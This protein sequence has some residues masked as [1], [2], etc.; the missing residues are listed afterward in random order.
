[1]L[2]QGVSKAHPE[3][4]SGSWERVQRSVQE[5]L[6]CGRDPLLVPPALELGLPWLNIS[7]LAF[8]RGLEKGTS[9]MTASQMKRP[10]LVSSGSRTIALPWGVCGW[11]RVSHRC[12]CSSL[13]P[14]CQTPGGFDVPAALEGSS[15]S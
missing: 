9:L 4:V 6:L 15:S 7:Q 11:L 1:M 12:L 10:L 13:F 14:G 5:N 8:T 2:T 3:P